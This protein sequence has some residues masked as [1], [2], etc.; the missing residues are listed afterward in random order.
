MSWLS[1]IRDDD[2]VVCTASDTKTYTISGSLFKTFFETP[3]PWNIHPGGIFH[4]KDGNNAVK[5]NV[6]VPVQAYS[7]DYAD[8]GLVTEVP[9]GQEMV[10]AVPED[11]TELFANNTGTW[12]F[13][14][15]T[16]TGKVENMESLFLNCSNF[17]G[18]IEGKFGGWNLSSCT[19]L[20]KTFDGCTVFNKPLI[21][22]NTEKVD[23]LVDTFKNCSAFNQ[24]INGWDVSGVKNLQGTFAGCTVFNSDLDTWDVSRCTRYFATFRDCKAFNGN[25]ETWDISAGK[26]FSQMFRNCENFEGSLHDWINIHAPEVDMMFMNAKKFAGDLS[27]WDVSKI[28]NFNSMFEGAERFNADI[29]FWQ[30]EVAKKMDK[31]FKNAKAFNYDLKLWCVIDIKSE[32]TEFDLGADAW[33]GGTAARPKWGTCV[34]PM[35]WELWNG[36]VFHVKDLTGPLYFGGMYQA[37]RPDGTSIGRPNVVFPPEE[38]IILVPPTRSG[39]EYQS[40]IFDNYQNETVN[41]NFGDK[42]NLLRMD[43]TT[44]MFRN[45]KSFNGSFGSSWNMSNI[46][47]MKAMFYNCVVFNKS[48]GSWRPGSGHKNG[49]TDTSEAFSACRKFNSELN[50][51]D[52]SRVTN[53]S[54][55]FNMLPTYQGGGVFNGNISGWNTSNVA[56]MS[57]MFEMGDFNGDITNW[58]VTNLVNAANMFQYCEKYNK[59]SG[60]SKWNPTKL[61]NVYAMFNGNKAMVNSNLNSWK[62]A[63]LTN[64]S[65]FLQGTGHS[66]VTIGE[67]NTTNVTDMSY[68]F[69]STFANPGTGTGSWDVSNV[70]NFSNFACTE[71]T[72]NGFATNLSNWDVSNAVNMSQMFLYAYQYN[73]PMNKWNTSKVTN[74]NNMFYRILSLNQDLTGWC[75]R[76]ITSRPNRFS[77]MAASKEPKW[78]QCPGNEDGLG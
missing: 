16:D 11:C 55:M 31:M 32:P 68:L 15:L 22:L 67:F 59:Q 73:F 23:D 26:K 17:N 19:S 24:D 20:R 44:R 40:G 41:W 9:A 6:S 30:T 14:N 78:S 64:M 38:A 29:S 1:N 76:K 39:D 27:L 66:V 57:G 18:L 58:N 4:I 8:L 35:P 56:D 71:S 47:N 2:L 46:T 3:P 49:L 10:L 74:M 13:G 77:E 7:V 69:A 28:E 53:M 37:F 75:V 65:R 12:N 34:I 5:L 63:P 48:I 50:S 54:E 25:V 42:T 51:W 60:L 36:G 45:C 52:T 62:V 70:T 72:V 21:F 43:Y 61:E 33:T